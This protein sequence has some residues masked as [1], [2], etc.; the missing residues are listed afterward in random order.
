M[1]KKFE[2]TDGPLSGA[3]LESEDSPGSKVKI[4]YC[5]GDAC[6]EQ[7]TYQSSAND[8][9]KFQYVDT[10]RFAETGH[11]AGGLRTDQLAWK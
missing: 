6:I 7:Y 4:T 11:V 9:G 5:T 1:S 2:F 3:I 8:V 10:K